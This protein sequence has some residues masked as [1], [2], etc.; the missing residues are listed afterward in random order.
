MSVIA[1]RYFGE[2]TGYCV[3]LRWNAVVVVVQDVHGRRVAARPVFPRSIRQT[4]WRLS[5]KGNRGNR[6]IVE[7]KVS[8]SW[9]WHHPEP[10][11]D[12]VKPQYL[13]ILRVMKIEKTVYFVR[14]AQ[15]EDNAAPVFQ[16]ENSPLS[17]IGRRQ[18]QRVA[19]RLSK[20]PFD[21]IIASPLPRAKETAET[22]AQATGRE[23]KYSKLFVERIKPARVRGKRY[24]DKEASALWR[25]W[26]KSLYTPGMR[27]ADGE[28]FDDLIIRADAALAF[29]RDLAEPSLVVVTHGYF[30]R[31][32]VARILLGDS[33][34]GEMFRRLQR[35]G[36]TENTGLTVLRYHDAFEEESCWRLWIHND[37]AHLDK[38]ED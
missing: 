5:K 38:G 3:L 28:N 9:Y 17:E 2:F 31:T 23:V 34:S 29:V 33:L 4:G 35:V 36:S 37:H 16:S 25:D 15:S 1:G 32:M 22:I 6:G 14:H 11:P 19:A 8:T 27:V 30:L 24:E 13:T 18:A 26:T 21:V 10:K 12:S 20:L 7:D